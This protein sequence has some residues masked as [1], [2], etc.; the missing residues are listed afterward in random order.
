MDPTPIHLRKSNIST[1]LLDQLLKQKRNLQ[2]NNPD[3][4]REQIVQIYTEIFQL[5]G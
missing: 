1:D 5:R 3:G 4:Y 2:K